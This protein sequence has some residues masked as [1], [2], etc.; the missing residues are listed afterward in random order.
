VGFL[1]WFRHFQNYSELWRTWRSIFQ[2]T[3]C[4]VPAAM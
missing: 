1:K 3:I 4:R 2:E